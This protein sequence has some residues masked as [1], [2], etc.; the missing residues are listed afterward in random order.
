MLYCWQSHPSN[1][2]RTVVDVTERKK[3]FEKDRA[4]ILCVK[5]EPHE[6][7]MLLH[8]EVQQMQWKASCKHLQ[9]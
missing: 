6:Q 1:S 4:M 3:N 2:C 9:Y 7:R 5:E 8:D